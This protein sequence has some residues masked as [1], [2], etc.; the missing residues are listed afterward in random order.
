MI[1]NCYF[2]TPPPFDLPATRVRD[3]TVLVLA[4]ILAFFTSILHPAGRV[5]LEKAFAMQIT[6]AILGLFG[7]SCV[8]AAPPAHE[9]PNDLLQDLNSQALDALKKAEVQSNKRSTCQKCSVSEA[10]VR[11]D[12]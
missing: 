7:A 2:F 12:W 8:G 5:P 4:L 9:T 10:A 3:Q 6:L 1:L 11:R